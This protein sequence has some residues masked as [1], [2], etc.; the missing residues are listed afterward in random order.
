ME[1]ECWDETGCEYFTFNLILPPSTPLKS[2]IE[3]QIGNVRLRTLNVISL[4][5]EKEPLTLKKHD[6]IAKIQGK[7]KVIKSQN[8]L[9]E[10]LEHRFD[11][12]LFVFDGIERSSQKKVLKGHHFNPMRTEVKPVSA[13]LNKTSSNA[14][15]SA[16]P[17]DTNSEIK[18]S[19][20]IKKS[21]S[22]LTKNLKGTEQ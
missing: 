4:S 13:S 16:K 21:L 9:N 3:D 12:E 22:K 18:R 10:Y 5:L 20:R 11:A 19:D 8:D 2:S 15:S 7:W 14:K 1:I 17:K 6:W